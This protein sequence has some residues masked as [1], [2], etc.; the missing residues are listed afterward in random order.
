VTQ[1]DIAI[2]PW[3]ISVSESCLAAL[4]KDGNAVPYN[5][6]VDVYPEI[7]V[8]KGTEVD[9]YHEARRR[10]L[11]YFQKN[12]LHVEKIYLFTQDIPNALHG[13]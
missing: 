4:D 7:C 13:I 11:F 3:E 9:A 8:F 12:S 5:F 1:N 10:G 6:E 2:H